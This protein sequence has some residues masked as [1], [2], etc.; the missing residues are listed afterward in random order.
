MSYTES[1]E[2]R[3]YGRWKELEQ[4]LHSAAKFLGAPIVNDYVSTHYRRPG[5][6]GGVE[7]RLTSNVEAAQDDFIGRELA[8]GHIT[9]FEAFEPNLDGYAEVSS[10]IQ[11]LLSFE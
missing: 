2:A 5:E 1:P 7:T 11:L 8:L 10:N 9:I 6:V 4:K 3:D